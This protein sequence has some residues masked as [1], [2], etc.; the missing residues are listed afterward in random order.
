M[1]Q[2]SMVVA[3]VALVASVIGFV[4]PTYASSNELPVPTLTYQELNN[5]TIRLF[6][7]GSFATEHHI[8]PEARNK[9]TGNKLADGSDEWRCDAIKL[10]GS[11]PYLD[12]SLSHGLS[13]RFGVIAHDPAAGVW[14]KWSS[15]HK[16]TN[17]SQV[18]P[19]IQ[20]TTTTVVVR[21]ATGLP[22]RADGLTWGSRAQIEKDHAQ[23]LREMSAILSR[24]R[25]GGGGLGIGSS[26]C[27]GICYG[28][29]SKVNGLPRNT[30]VSGYY[31]SDGTWVNPYTRSNP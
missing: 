3:I 27:V 11:N 26:D 16:F 22:R 25:I 13:E 14:S 31:R 9:P 30:Y 5:S 15:W 17:N 2:K 21:N 18:Q 4:S 24:G 28:V 12:Y 23:L 10:S 20:T 1:K 8:C 7:S 6:V 29:P 19:V